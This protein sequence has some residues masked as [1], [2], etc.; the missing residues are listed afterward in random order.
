[1]LAEICRLCGEYG[2]TRV[3]VG[4][5]LFAAIARYPISR[6]VREHRS[7]QALRFV[8]ARSVGCRNRSW[9]NEHSRSMVYYRASASRA[10]FRSTDHCLAG[11]LLT[12]ISADDRS[13]LFVTNAPQPHVT[14]QRP[15]PPPTT[16]AQSQS[17]L[18]KPSHLQKPT[19]AAA[20]AT[21]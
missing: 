20:V 15:K 5:M 6:S 2:R 11:F 14:L 10:W 13:S 4:G 3:V 12:S 8:V 16:A 17:K 1:M 21:S 19:K 9:V 18:P 7:T